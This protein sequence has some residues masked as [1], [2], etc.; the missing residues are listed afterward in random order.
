M[1]RDEDRLLSEEKK[2]IGFLADILWDIMTIPELRDNFTD[3]DRDT[4]NTI[5]NHFADDYWRRTATEDE[6]EG[7]WDKT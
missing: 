5:R 2:M 7:W 3:S 6:D 4:V 1:S